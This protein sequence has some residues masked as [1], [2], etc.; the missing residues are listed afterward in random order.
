MAYFYEYQNLYTK[1]SLNT[2]ILSHPLNLLVHQV[3]IPAVGT[4]ALFGRC[5]SCLL[6]LVYARFCLNF[7]VLILCSNKNVITVNNS[8]KFDRRTI[9]TEMHYYIL[10]FESNDIGQPYFHRTSYCVRGFTGLSWSVVRLL[11]IVWFFDRSEGR[12]FLQSHLKLKTW[13]VNIVREY[14]FERYRRQTIIDIDRSRL[15]KRHK[16]QSTGTMIGDR[17]N[18]W[19]C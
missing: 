6:F 8:A 9:Q 11:T 15:V 1:Y 5:R 13:M 16:D 3:V 17:I 14:N 7:S 12:I 18:A 10:E 2:I 4:P 19:R